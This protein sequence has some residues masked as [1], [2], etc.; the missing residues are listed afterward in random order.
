MKAYTFTDENGKEI[1]TVRAENHDDAVLAAD[2]LGVTDD[3][4]FDYETIED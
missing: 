2:H 3:T 4:D 1:V